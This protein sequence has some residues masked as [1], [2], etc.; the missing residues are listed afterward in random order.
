MKIRRFERYEGVVTTYV[1]GAGRIGVMVKFDTDVD[2]TKPE[3]KEFAKDIAMQV[4]AANPAY[5]D[6]AAVPAEVIAKE[7][8]ILMAQIANDPKSANKPEAVIAKMVEGKIGKYYKENCLMQQDFVKDN[9]VTVS[10][11][12]NAVAKAAGATA[13]IVKFERFVMGEGLAKKNEDFA[14][15]IAK[16][17]NK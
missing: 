15:E 6:E 4:A 8:E 10:Q 5:L 1:H 11:H 2:T 16:I 13:S 3:F 9:T 12:L 7:K 14:A 17:T